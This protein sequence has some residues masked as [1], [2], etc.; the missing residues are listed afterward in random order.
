MM[1]NTSRAFIP[2][3]D[4]HLY[5]AH[6]K[7]QLNGIVYF[8]NMHYWCEVLSTQLGYKTGWYHYDGMRNGG[9]AQYVGEKPH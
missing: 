5:I 4:G 1:R 8:N 3:L 7:Y 9:K 6:N 2:K